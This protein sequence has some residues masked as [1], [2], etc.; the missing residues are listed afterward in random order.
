[1]DISGLS[2]LLV[3]QKGMLVLSTASTPYIL[4]EL[5]LKMF[6]VGFKCICN[7]VFK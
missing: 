7:P 6:I 4:C 3:K 2:A 5:H 1:M